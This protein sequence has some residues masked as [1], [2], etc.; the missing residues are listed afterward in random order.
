MMIEQLLLTKLRKNEPSHIRNHLRQHR[1]T[2]HDQNQLFLQQTLPAT[3][4]Q[5]RSVFH[6]T[7]RLTMLHVHRHRMHV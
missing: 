7:T 3:I 5:N 1:S 6:V 2:L 4:V